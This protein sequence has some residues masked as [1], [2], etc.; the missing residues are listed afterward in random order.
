MKVLLWYAVPFVGKNANAVPRFKDKSLRF[1]RAARRLRARS[2]LSRGAAVP[3][4]HLHAGASRLGTSTASSWT[5]SSASSPTTRPCWTQSGGR[6]FASVNEATDR[7]MTDV[8]AEL[9]KIKPDVMIEFRQ[10]YIGPLIRKY[11]NMF[12]ASDCPN[13]YLATG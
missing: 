2:A 11:G 9:K 12:R 3:D 10:P 7:L 6:D 13:S 1:T 4:R 8:L 5:S